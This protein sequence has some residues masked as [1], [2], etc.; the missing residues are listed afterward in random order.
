MWKH[1]YTITIETNTFDPNEL[2]MELTTREDDGNKV[3]KMLAGDD[4]KVK[5]QKSEYVEDSK[6]RIS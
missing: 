5:H 1:T 3:H 2:I 6:G 4:I